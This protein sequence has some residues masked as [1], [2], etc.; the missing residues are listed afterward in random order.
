MTDH[1]EIHKHLLAILQANGNPNAKYTAKPVSKK[2]NQIYNFEIAVN[3]KH[4]D[5]NTITNWIEG[6]YKGHEYTTD[7]TVGYICCELNQMLIGVTVT[8]IEKVR[9]LVTGTD[10]HASVNL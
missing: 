8:V 5:V 4:V 2:E 1:I 6:I 7:S 3:Q 9:I 10:L